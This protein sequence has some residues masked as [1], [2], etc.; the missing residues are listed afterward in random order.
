MSDKWRKKT[1][2]VARWTFLVLLHAKNPLAGW[3][4]QA[5]TTQDSRVDDYRIL[6]LVRGKTLHNIQ[7]RQQHRGGGRIALTACNQRMSLYTFMY[8]YLP[9]IK[10]AEPGPSRWWHTR[11]SAHEIKARTDQTRPVCVVRKKNSG[12]KMIEAVWRQEAELSRW[13]QRAVGRINQDC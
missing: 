9:Y 7:P 12:M 11:M 10:G 1:L 4:T 8:A 5:E 2:E 3:S 6:S 13:L